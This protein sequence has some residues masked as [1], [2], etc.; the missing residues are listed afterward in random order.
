MGQH[1]R[2]L[3]EG[4]QFAVSRAQAID[5]NGRVDEDHATRPGR[6]RRIAL[7]PGSVPPSLASRRAL[8]RAINASRPMRTS[9]VF[10]ETPVNRTARRRRDGS[11]FKVVRIYAL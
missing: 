8:S 10:L 9:A 6:R 3:Q 7:N 5:P 4:S 1:L 11:M 2:V